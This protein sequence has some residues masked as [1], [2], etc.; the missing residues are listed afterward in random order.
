MYCTYIWLF[1]YKAT[2]VHR[3]VHGLCRWHDR[4]DNRNSICMKPFKP[5]SVKYLFLKH[6][7]EKTTTEQN[8]K[9]A[10]F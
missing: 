9:G 8:I 3:L 1:T 5:I 4:N 2:T 6:I 10:T 7:E